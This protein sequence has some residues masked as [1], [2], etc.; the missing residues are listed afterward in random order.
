MSDLPIPFEDPAA[1][2]LAREVL[3]LYET[4]ARDMAETVVE[5]GRRLDALGQL[6]PQGSMYRWVDQHAPFSRRAAVN[7][8]RLARFAQERPADFQRWKHLG[9]SKLYA[10]TTL[11]WEGLRVMRRRKT[12]PVGPGERRTLERMS[13]AQLYARVA[14]LRGDPAQPESTRVLD[15]A[16]RRARGL[17]TVADTLVGL[18][19]VAEEDARALRD[20]LADLVARLDDDPETRTHLRWPRRPLRDRGAVRRVAGRRGADLP[21][22]PGPIGPVSVRVTPAASILPARFAAGAMTR[23][24]TATS[25]NTLPTALSTACPSATT[26]PAPSNGPPA[27]CSAGATSSVRPLRGEFVRRTVPRWVAWRDPNRRWTK[28]FGQLA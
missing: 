12:H 2:A 13:V 22:R 6:V 19:D 21:G 23:T 14:S 7:Y 27:T 3:Q 11:G 4:A 20:L 8:L 17:A 1:V 26:S 24:R 28:P 16:R 5:I 10:I 18:D 15:S 9:P 25:K